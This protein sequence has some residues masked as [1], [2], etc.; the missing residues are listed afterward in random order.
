MEV[1]TDEDFALVLAFRS[2]KSGADVNAVIDGF[3]VC[4]VVFL[5]STVVMVPEGGLSSIL[6]HEVS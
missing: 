2:T 5:V 1:V 6:G 3:L 4:D